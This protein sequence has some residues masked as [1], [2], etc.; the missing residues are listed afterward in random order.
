M[1]GGSRGVNLKR[2]IQKSQCQSNLSNQEMPPTN[3]RTGTTA[4]EQMM[5]RR[6]Q[7]EIS[8]AGNLSPS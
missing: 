5:E 4:S 6:D 2:S 3:Q 7:G 1:G 8:T